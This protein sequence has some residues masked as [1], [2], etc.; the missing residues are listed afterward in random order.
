MDLLIHKEDRW[1]T[2]IPEEY[3]RATLKSLKTR[4]VTFTS[5]DENNEYTGLSI[6]LHNIDHKHGI[7]H[8]EICE[9]CC[10]AHFWM[11]ADDGS[12]CCI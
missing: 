6:K 2:N 11:D 5:Y 10:S 1:I 8:A 12:N 9:G 4:Y 3:Q 7:V